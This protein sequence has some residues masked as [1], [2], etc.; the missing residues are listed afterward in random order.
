VTNTLPSDQSASQLMLHVMRQKTWLEDLLLDKG[1]NF[2]SGRAWPG[3][4]GL[5]P[6]AEMAEWSPGAAV[7]G[8]ACASDIKVYRMFRSH[9]LPPFE[10]P[11]PGSQRDCKICRAFQLTAGL[12]QVT[13]QLTDFLTHRWLAHCI[14]LLVSVASGARQ[15]PLR[16]A[17]C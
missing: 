11:S 5:L 7:L 1:K 14:T 4:L 16:C 8:S 12:V 17:H 6:G 13:M 15:F 3:I 10:Q 9:S 2:L